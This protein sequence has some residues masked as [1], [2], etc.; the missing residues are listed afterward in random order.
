MA[1][2]FDTFTVAKRGL[3]V[4]QG[5][6]NTTSHNIANT[7]TIGYSRQRATVQTTRP[8]GGSSR[9]DGGT[10]GQVGTGAEITQ[11]MRIRDSFLDYQVRT[12]TTNYGTAITKNQYLYQVEDILNETTSTGVQGALSAFYNAFQELSKAPEKDSN[13][14]VALQQ[15]SA[16]ADALNSR[17]TQL[18]N[19]K[20]DAQKELSE[21]VTDINTML[22]Q[23]NDLN[24]QISSV[25]AVGM[26]PNDLMDS[27]DYLIDQLSSKFGVKID[28]QAHE[29]VDLSVTEDSAIGNLV[30]SNPNDSNY[31]RFSYIENAVVN[32]NTLTVTYN[33]LGD[34][35]NQKTIEITDTDINKLEELK[36]NLL[37][38]RILVGDKD[39]LVTNSTNIT[40]DSSTPGTTP[41]ADEE[42]IINLLKNIKDLNDV[43]RAVTPL[44]AGVTVNKDGS[45]T[46]SET[47]GTKTTTIIIS[48]NGSA[49]IT[50]S[51]ENPDGTKTETQLLKANIDKN[52]NIIASTN[53]NSIGDIT[54]ATTIKI[55]KNGDASKLVKTIPAPT[56]SLDNMDSRIFNNVT[57]GEIAGNQQ[58]QDDIQSY[59]DKLDKFTVSFAYA[60][61]AIQTGST[62]DGASGIDGLDADKAELIFVV[63]NSD[64]SLSSSDTG[65]TAKNIK[66]NSKLE[67]DTSLLNCGEK[68]VDDISGDK[69]GSR[70]LAIAGLKNLKINTGSL[71]IEDM[72]SRE[73]FFNKSGINFAK[74]DTSKLNLVNTNGGTGSKLD[75]YYKTIIS[76]LATTSKAAQK[77][78]KDKNVIL[79]ALDNQRLSISAVSLD[80]EMSDLIQFQHSYQANAKMINTIDELLDVVINGLKR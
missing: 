62:V 59:M 71:K 48:Q 56:L 26:T 75:E 40:L 10:V 73:D 2:L 53:T 44:P 31:S 46:K 67:K 27:R 64:G 78:V 14:T 65:I 33:V 13:R 24:K 36:N 3:N 69:D 12:E 79:T 35:N 1:G 49:T 68:H 47:V 23:I 57:K 8:F 76:D 55:N 29:T 70:A 21:Y 74:A 16:L 32:G 41:T 37:Q 20:Q 15:A 60:V 54:T 61:N 72:E 25:V 4:Q 45:I 5:N 43:D 66:I 63:G 50:E 52:E 6:I 42:K 22:D 77:D 34:K 58:V 51:N 17:Y 38:D 28:K 30:N 80:E 9:F 7:N 39:G 11:I 19:K 18:E